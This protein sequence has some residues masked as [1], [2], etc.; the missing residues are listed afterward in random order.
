MQQTCSEQR[1]W[2]KCQCHNGQ[3]RQIIHSDDVERHTHTLQYTD[4]HRLSD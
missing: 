1:L 2:L 3:L 4:Q